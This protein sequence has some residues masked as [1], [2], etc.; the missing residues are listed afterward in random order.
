MN[1]VISFIV[2]SYNCEKFLDKCLGSFLNEEVL[3]KIEVVVVNDGSTDSTEQKALEYADKYPEVFK[4]ISQKNR[5]HGGALNAGTQAAT[6]KYLKPIDADDW[7]VRDNLPTYVKALEETDSDVVLT[8]HHTI[9]MTTGEKLK[10]MT[11]PD[12]FG[13]KYTLEEIMDNWKSFDRSLTFHGITYRTDFYKQN[14]L[15]LSEHVFYEDHEFATIPCCLAQSVTPLDVFVYQYRIGDTE[16]SVSDTNQLKRIN[17]TEAVLKRLVKEQNITYDLGIQSGGKRYYEQKTQGLLLSFFTT[18]ALV[19]PNKPR[20][21]SNAKRLMTYFRKKMPGV[22]A[23]AESQYRV[24][25]ALNR[26]HISKKT[27]KK[28]LGTKL[29]NKLRGN[30]SFN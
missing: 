4:V 17:H 7:V 15:S 1:K 14:A 3:D 20:G 22:A 13:E 6:G 24:Y 19:D 18:A 27:Y 23:L 12:R 5:G 11:Y 28:I 26:L 30:H 21:R 8:H 2:P 16:Q 29:Y 10:W 9:D 25:M